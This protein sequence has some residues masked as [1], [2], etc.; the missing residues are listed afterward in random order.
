MS[1]NNKNKS[2]LIVYNFEDEETGKKSVYEFEAT[3]Q[4]F[5]RHYIM[6]RHAETLK[7]LMTI[8][9]I[10]KQ[11]CSEN[12]KNTNVIVQSK[13]NTVEN[14]RFQIEFICKAG[15]L[16]NI[17]P[18]AFIIFLNILFSYEKILT[19]T[20]NFNPYTSHLLSDWDFI[21]NSFKIK[22]K[23][24]QSEEEQIMELL[25][26][27]TKITLRLK[28]ENSDKDKKDNCFDGITENP[29][30]VFFDT[31]EGKRFYINPFFW[32]DYFIFTKQCKS[33]TPNFLNYKKK[34]MR[35]MFL[36]FCLE[37]NESNRSYI[38][39]TNAIAEYTFYPAANLDKNSKLKK[40]ERIINDL[41]TVGKSR[42]FSVLNCKYDDKNYTLE[43]LANSS[44]L[45]DIDLNDV[46]ISYKIN[47]E[48][49]DYPINFETNGNRESYV[50]YKITD[51][52]R[53]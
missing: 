36:A 19:E 2:T 20:E 25:N 49:L 37:L 30:L 16:E 34:Q 38:K 33:L 14:I 27:L 31:E 46:Y 45:T 1:E 35:L 50:V 12:K 21:F 32:L 15:D 7:M 23:S 39:L 18:Y 40:K 41:K 28:S 6:L 42:L 26:P 48:K 8:I 22:R 11:N 29:L 53:I 13:N 3:T 24:N 44:I 9:G 4:H 51:E 5:N 10:S 17:S 52:Y 47:K 43:E